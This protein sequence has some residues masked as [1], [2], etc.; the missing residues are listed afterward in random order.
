MPNKFQIKRTSVSG[1]TPNTTN[2]ANSAYIDAG[3]LAVNLTDGKLF[4]SNG[5]V[6]FEVGAN[7]ENQYIGSTLTVVGNTTANNINMQDSVL[8]RPILKDY[9]LTHNPLG[10]VTG[11]TTIDLALGNFVSATITG[12][13]QFTF[14]NPAPTANACGFILELTNGGSATITWPSSVTKWP[15]GSAP[16]LTASGVDVLVFIT[17]DSGSTWR[18]VLSMGDSK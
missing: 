16:S 18:G 2:V 15:G 17:D 10:S 11:A 6:Y 3:E 9:A 1:R 7:V 13:T 12:A 5:S 8:T 4:S 14:S